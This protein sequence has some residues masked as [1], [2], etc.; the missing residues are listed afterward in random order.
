LVIKIPP[1]EGAVLMREVYGYLY[2]MGNND[3]V[4]LAGLFEEWGFK[5]YG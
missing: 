2:E 4:E 5:P 1:P 3:A